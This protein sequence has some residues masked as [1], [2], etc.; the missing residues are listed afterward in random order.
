[1]KNS[2]FLNQLS[3]DEATLPSDFRQARE[4]M[5]RDQIAARGVADKSVLDAMRMMRKNKI[6][7]LPVIHGEKL[8]GIITETDLID[9]SASLLEKYL[10]E[11]K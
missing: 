7:C 5:V 11:A 8:V 6:G 2:V 10:S 3:T 1:M 9:V 4:R